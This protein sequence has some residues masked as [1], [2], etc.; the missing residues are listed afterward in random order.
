MQNVTLCVF[1]SVTIVD[2]FV[3]VPTP[4]MD[5]IPGFN[6]FQDTFLRHVLLNGLYSLWVKLCLQ[7]FM[8]LFLCIE[9]Q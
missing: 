2:I 7:Q 9:E 8:L 6:F 1:K 4:L 5:V 3:T